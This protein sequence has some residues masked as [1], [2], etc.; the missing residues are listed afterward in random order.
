MT[1]FLYVF[2][3]CFAID[4]DTLRCGT[5]RVRLARID[6]PEKREAGFREAKDAMRLLIEGKEV[7]CVVSRREKYGRLLGECATRDTPNLSDAMLASGLAE[8]YR[9]RR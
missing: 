8:R 2:A 5:E 3:L 6:T 9:G 4:G 7:R 1:A